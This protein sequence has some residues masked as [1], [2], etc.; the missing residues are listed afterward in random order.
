MKAICFILMVIKNKDLSK[1]FMYRF[2]IFAATKV[3]IALGFCVLKLIYFILCLNSVN[4]YLDTFEKIRTLDC[5][6]DVQNIA[7]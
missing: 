4:R 7:F 6:D 5:T 1:R 3:V 2:N